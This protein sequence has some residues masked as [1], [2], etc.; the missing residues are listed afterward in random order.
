[1]CSKNTIKIHDKNA[2]INLNVNENTKIVSKKSRR[3]VCFLTFV[4]FVLSA[5]HVIQR[6]FFLN[7]ILFRITVAIARTRIKKRCF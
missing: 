2:V 7:D 4:H 6:T 5:L 1:M 3:D